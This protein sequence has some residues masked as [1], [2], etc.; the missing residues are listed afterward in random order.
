MQKNIHINIPP[1]PPEGYV[2]NTGYGRV[3]GDGR[4]EMVTS[5]EGLE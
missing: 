1:L 5:G 3:G 2:N 4:G